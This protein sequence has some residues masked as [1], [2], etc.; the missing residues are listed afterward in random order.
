M[1]Y[2]D[3]WFHF[4]D[5]TESFEQH[6]DKG[7]INPDSICFIKESGQVYTQNSLFGI[8]R[9]RY[10]RLEQLAKELNDRS[11]GTLAEIE[12]SKRDINADFDEFKELVGAPEGIA[13]LDRD[14]KIPAAYLP[15]YVDDVLEYATRAAF[16]VT[17]ETGKIYV[18]LDD[19]LTYRWSG[20]TYIEI[21][22]S[23]GLGETSSTAYPGSKGKKNADDIAA[24]KIDY[25]NPHRVTKVQVGLGN[26]DN[27]SDLDK[28]VSNAAK[29]EFGSIKTRMNDLENTVSISYEALR[30]TLDTFASEVGEAMDTKVDKV[31]G[32][33]LS[34]NDFTNEDKTKL[35]S[36]L[37]S[38][39]IISAGKVSGDLS[40]SKI[41]LNNIFTERYPGDTRVYGTIP[42]ANVSGTLTNAIME[43]SKVSG[44]LTNATINAGKIIDYDNL[45][46]LVTGIISGVRIKGNIPYATISGSQVSGHLSNATIDASNVSGLADFIPTGGGDSTGIIEGSRVSGDLVNATINASKII[47]WGGQG[48]LITGVICGDRIHGLL[49][50]AT[51]DASDVYGNLTNANI[52]VKGVNNLNDIIG[53]YS[54]GSEIHYYVK[55]EKLR[56]ISNAT[57]IGSQVSG[58]LSMATISGSRIYDNINGT[59]I[60]GAIDASRI[61]GNLVNAEIQGSNITGYIDVSKLQ[62]TIN[63]TLVTG[64]IN[65][66]NI[67]GGFLDSVLIPASTIHGKLTNATIDSSN[68]EGTITAE[69]ILADHSI[70]STHLDTGAVIP[71][72]IAS[73]NLSS[74]VKVNVNALVG[75]IPAGRLQGNIDKERMRSGFLDLCQEYGVAFNSTGIDRVD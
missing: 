25:S 7:L 47:D 14:T 49:R 52:D 34:T 6:R 35:T 56:G 33:G 23:L 24:H 55:A 3:S 72:D 38:T 15:S 13:P 26:V 57:I 45:G 43:G 20:S 2:I 30:G 1:N 19:N 17:G 37:T 21:S 22:K 58:N 40:N 69:Q 46:R 11:G 44:E 4:Y 10:E 62:D 48:E 5:T 18:S 32:K 63:D 67:S 54:N 66:A 53:S 16:P 64:K 71:E 41:N 42:G 36:A 9:E 74:G 65:A 31:E 51:I 39:S 28:P 60:S 8:C 70:T 29:T 68:I 73:G 27:T 12:Q 75:N 50:N 59:I 61:Q